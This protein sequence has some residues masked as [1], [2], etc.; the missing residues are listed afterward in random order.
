[1]KVLPAI[2]HPSLAPHAEEHDPSG[3]R[4]DE[5]GHDANGDALRRALNHSARPSPPCQQTACVGRCNDE[6]LAGHFF[7]VAVIEGTLNVV[8][9]EDEARFEEIYSQCARAVLAYLVR[10]V[11]R[12]D[13]RDVAADTFM[14]VWRRVAE[15]PQEPLPWVLAVARNQMRNAVRGQQRRHVLQVRLQTRTDRS[16]SSG[17]VYPAGEDEGQQ[18]REALAVLSAADRE[19]LLLI[20]WDG[21]DPAEAAQVLGLSPGTFRVRLHRARRRLAAQMPPPA[22]NQG[23]SEER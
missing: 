11:P 18:L 22:A 16:H 20:A 21:L 2:R 3:H 8:S 4:Y 12:D 6:P 7:A 14:V 10:E 13:A 15:V 23:M 5:S 9:A 19:V 1:M 17:G